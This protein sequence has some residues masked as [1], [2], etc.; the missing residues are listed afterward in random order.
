[1]YNAG[2]YQNTMDF[3]Q[4]ELWEREIFRKQLGTSAN[5]RNSGNVADKASEEIHPK[6]FSAIWMKCACT[7]LRSTLGTGIRLI[8][9]NIERFGACGTSNLEVG[10]CDSKWQ[11]NS[12]HLTLVDLSPTLYRSPSDFASCICDCS[13]GVLCYCT[14]VLHKTCSIHM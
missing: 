14:D 8:T 12:L 13:Y 9:G 4:D 6:S 1:M 11:A 2:Q 10:V 5:G 3:W 7:Y